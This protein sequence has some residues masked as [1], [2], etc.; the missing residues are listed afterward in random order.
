MVPAT[1]VTIAR[2]AV[3]SALGRPERNAHATS[4]YGTKASAPSVGPR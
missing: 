2:M 1:R 3:S 4:A